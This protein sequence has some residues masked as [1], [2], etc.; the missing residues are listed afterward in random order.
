M[1]RILVVDDEGSVRRLMRVILE[2]EGHEVIEA[3]DGRYALSALQKDGP[4]DLVV[5]DLM[6]P[7]VDGWEVLRNLD[8]MPPK[9]IVVTAREDEYAE[10]RAERT[11]PVFRYIIKP[12]EPDELV[13][14]VRE[15]LAAT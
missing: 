8:W 5:L 7:W 4:F 11:H 12:Y 10:N 6:M 2:M 1:S 13:D 9:V 15:A 14:A 3:E